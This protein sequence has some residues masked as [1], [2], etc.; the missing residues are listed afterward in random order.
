MQICNEIYIAIPPNL[1]L[2]NREI[3]LNLCMKCTKICR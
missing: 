3:Y 1:D 2:T